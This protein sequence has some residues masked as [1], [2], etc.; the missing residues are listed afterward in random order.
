[1]R[2]RDFGLRGSV[3]LVTGASGGVGR[4][5]AHMLAAAGARLVLQGRN[6]EAL[7]EVARQTAGDVV[8]LDLTTP[9][10]P[11]FL[12]SEA[13]RLRGRVDVLVNNAGVGWAG[14]FADM[15]AD[16]IGPLIALNLLAPVR[17]PGDG[18]TADH[19]L[20]RY[21]RRPQRRPSGARSRKAL[22]RSSSPAV[23][24]SW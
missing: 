3:C 16:R 2:H 5:T 18:P 13:R 10:A 1:M 12:F 7:L 4:A 9:G 22:R 19:G 11:H 14:E 8:V 15:P 20:G 23:F 17:H 6:E 21:R 24:G